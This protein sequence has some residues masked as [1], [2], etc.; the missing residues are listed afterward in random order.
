MDADSSKNM[1]GSLS[2]FPAMGNF[3]HRPG[4]LWYVTFSSASLALP[5]VNGAQARRWLLRRMVAIAL[6]IMSGL[7]ALVVVQQ[8][9]TID[10]QRQLIRQLF[11]D[12][13]ALNAARMKLAQN[14]R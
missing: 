10:S 4:L 7:M 12:S 14:K 8:N 2:L 13:L 1:P 9:R 5:R 11:Q 3:R 6:S